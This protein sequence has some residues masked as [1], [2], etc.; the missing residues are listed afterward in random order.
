MKPHSWAK[1]RK[2]GLNRTRLPSCSAT[3][4]ARLSNHSSRAQPP[5]VA[6]AW[7]W[8]RTKVSK[9]W[10][11]VNSRYILRLWHS[12][13]QKAYSLRGVPVVEQGA[14]VPPI[15]VEALARRRLHSH[16]RSAQHGILAHRQQVILEDRN[17]TLIAKRLQSLQQNRRR[18]LWVLFEQLCQGRLESVEFAGPVAPTRRRGGI[19]QVLGQVMPPDPEVVRDSALGPLLDQMQAVNVIDLFRAEHRYSTSK[20]GRNERP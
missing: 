13:R 17:A 20:P 16:V 1:A 15:D 11:W 10:L 5:S 12:T 9:V 19:V 18:G 6:K 2:R 8:H 3:A 14:E 4:V 7:M